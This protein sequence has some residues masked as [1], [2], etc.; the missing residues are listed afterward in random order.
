LFAI[1]KWYDD[2]E[3]H[4]SKV[5]FFGKR[6]QK[7]AVIFAAARP[8]SVFLEESFRQIIGKSLCSIDKHISRVFSGVMEKNLPGE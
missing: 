1:V 6:L 4:F 8:A 2:R 3:G 5:D 7:E